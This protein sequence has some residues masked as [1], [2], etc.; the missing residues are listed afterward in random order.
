VSS[1]HDDDIVKL[2]DLTTLCSNLMDDVTDN[3]FT[4]PV[5]VLLYRVARNMHDNSPQKSN[6]IRA[7]LK[8]CLDLLDV[9]KHAQV[10]PVYRN[11]LMLLYCL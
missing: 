1:G 2:Y 3:P 5:G 6:V 11:V 9:D 4:V 10:S 7:L 8:N